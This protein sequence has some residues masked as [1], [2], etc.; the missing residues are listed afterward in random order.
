MFVTLLVICK[1]KV[2]KKTTVSIHLIGVKT[3][4]TKCVIAIFVFKWYTTLKL[5]FQYNNFNF[6]GKCK[7]KM[8]LIIVSCIVNLFLHPFSKHMKAEFLDEI[9]HTLRVTM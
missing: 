7:Y 6:L 1:K 2:L 5:K 9:I 8:N 3:K 4:F